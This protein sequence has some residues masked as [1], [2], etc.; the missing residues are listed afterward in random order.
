[1]PLRACA[2]DFS[3]AEALYAVVVHHADSLHEGVADRRPHEVEAALLEIFAHCIGF[4]SAGRNS[5]PRAPGVDP[6]FTAY[7]LPGVV[8]ERTKLFLDGEKGLRI[9]YRGRDL[10]PVANDAG[11]AQQTRNLRRS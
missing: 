3:V 10:E 4:G 7:E 5:L 2:V 11:I 8:V 6:R 1:M 9:A